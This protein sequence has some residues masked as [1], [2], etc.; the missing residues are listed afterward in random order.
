M[1]KFLIRA[2]NALQIFLLKHP[3]GFTSWLLNFFYDANVVE[4]SL[5]G[6]TGQNYLTRRQ[7]VLGQN[8]AALGK[9]IVGSHEEVARRILA[10]QKRAGYLSPLVLMEDRFSEYFMLFLSDKGAGGGD[11]F[12]QLYDTVWDLILGPAVERTKE[13]KAK[14]EL[15]KFVETAYALGNPPDAKKLQ[16]PLQDWVM[17]YVL[18][19]T[20]EV[21]ATDEQIEVLNPF[22]Y[23]TTPGKAL[24]FAGAK[25]FARKEVSDTVTAARVMFEE[26]VDTSPV[27]QGFD[28]AN[29]Y[30]LD[31]KKFVRLMVEIL[32]LAGFGG[33]NNLSNSLLTKGTI[34][35][36]KVD[37]DDAD[38]VEKV[39]LETARRWAPVNLVNAIAQEP[40]T[41]P[42]NG[43]SHTFPAGTTLAL[44][45]SLANLD[46]AVFPDPTGFDPDRAGLCPHF[47]SFNSVGDDGQRRCPG[48]GVAVSMVSQL[49]VAWQKKAAAEAAA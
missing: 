39:V 19:T 25:P 24:L 49:F 29:K 21:E 35:S 18:W 9:V 20:L 22:V 46:P 41:V 44:S 7:A 10:P 27:M 17:R 16:K 40:V 4:F 33:S 43:K 8:F 32:T 5:E 30:D 6:N 12:Q 38:A 45:L 1:D 36:T 3:N 34:I 15:E 42:I 37:L 2:S 13:A 31:R 11:L 23:G 28:A 48:R 14:A 26:M 47:V